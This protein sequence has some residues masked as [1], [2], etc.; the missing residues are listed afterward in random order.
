MCKFFEVQRS[1]TINL[2]FK[3]K[4]N[5]IFNK[6]EISDFFTNQ[7]YYLWGYYDGIGEPISLTPSQY[8]DRFIYS[9]DFMNVEEVGY[10]EVLS[11]GNML[12]NQFEVYDN[13]IVVEYYFPGISPDFGGMDW[14]SLRLV[15][16]QYGDSWY[17][18]GIIHNQWTI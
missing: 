12:E 11:Y 10:N 8:Y 16:K 1:F 3:R 6:E 9:K 13:A 4:N 17:L 2:I 18:V 5:R 14:E 7:E 15:F